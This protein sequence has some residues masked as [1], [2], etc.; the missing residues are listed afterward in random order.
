MSEKS[1]VKGKQIR[2]GGLF[3][4]PRWGFVVMM[5]ILIVVIPHARVQLVVAVLRRLPVAGLARLTPD[6]HYT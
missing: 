1:S 6:S 4:N 3:I 2:R 5:T